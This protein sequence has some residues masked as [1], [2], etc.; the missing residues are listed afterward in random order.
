MKIINKSEVTKAFFVK[1]VYTHLKPNSTMD[2]P[3]EVG[4][5]LIKACPTEVFV[6]SD[7]KK[8]VSDGKKE[9]AP[10][11]RRGRRSS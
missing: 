6:V 3:E 2:V 1:R 11:K 8:I 9:D 7:G 4:K 5:A 10:V